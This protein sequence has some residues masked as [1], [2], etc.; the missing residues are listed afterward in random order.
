M[1]RKTTREITREITR[2]L[3]SHATTQCDTA[4][5]QGQRARFFPKFI[6][7]ALL[8]TLGAGVVPATALTLKTGEVMAKDGSVHVGASPRNRAN[9]IAN[10]KRRDEPAGVVGNN[11]FVVVG[12]SITFVPT[13]ELRGKTKESMVAIV[14]DAVVQEITGLAEVSFDEVMAVSQISESTGVEIDKLLDR[15]ELALLDAETLQ[16]IRDF[17]TETGLSVE[18]LVAVNAVLEKLPADEVEHFIDELETMVDDGL[19]DEVGSFMSDLSQIEGGIET[20]LGFEGY[21]EC[22]AGGGGSVC[23]QVQAAHDNSGLE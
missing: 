12:D 15:E 20:F 1:A 16:E 14:G 4:P 18:N 3:M 2:E 21:D 5:P 8:L 9:M 17:S 19:A 23:D 10:A 6:A 22:V 13:R 11:V 7:A